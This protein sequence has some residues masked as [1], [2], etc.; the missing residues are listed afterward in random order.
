[1][2]VKR[3]GTAGSLVPHTFFKKALEE[4][5]GLRRLDDAFTSE[6]VEPPQFKAPTARLTFKPYYN[7]L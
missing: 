4:R 6:G 7:N 2:I 3:P 5:L 1:M